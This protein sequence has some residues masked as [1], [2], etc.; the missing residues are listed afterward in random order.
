MFLPSLLWR[1]WLGRTK[2]I[3]PAKNW[4][5]GCWRGYLSGARCD[6]HMIQLMP[7][8]LYLDSIKSTLVSPFRYRLTRILPDKWPFNGYC[9]CLN[10]YILDVPLWE[11]RNG[12]F[13]RK[14]M[15]EKYSE[16]L[17]ALVLCGLAARLC[18]SKAPCLRGSCVFAATCS[19]STWSRTF[20]RRIGRFTRVTYFWC[21]VA[22]GRLSSKWLRLIHRRTAL[23]RQT[24]WS[25][26]RVNPSKERSAAG[27]FCMVAARVRTRGVNRLSIIRNSIDKT[28]IDYGW[29]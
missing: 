4:V 20:W 14:S 17:R 25:T 1:C 7:L 21:A 27:L 15:K 29:R 8:P 18:Y 5:V 12:S 22:W 26:V 3:Q 16:T 11:V 9:C 6:L 24:P 13:L 28:I 19:M 2:D 23:W 10:Y